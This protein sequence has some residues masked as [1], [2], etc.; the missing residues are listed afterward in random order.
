VLGLVMNII[1]ALVMV[2]VMI[3]MFNLLGMR[4]SAVRGDF[5]LYIMS[6]V[7]NYATHSKAIS[8]VARS[9][10]PTST[11]MQHAPMNT[12]V[13]ICSSALSALY[14]QTLSAFCILFFY[15]T[16]W[17]RITIYDPVGVFGMYLL[18]WASGIGVGMILKAATPWQPEFF[19]IITMLYTRAN[20][21]FSGKMFLANTLSER[22]LYLYSWNPLFHCIDQTRG[23][24][25]ENYHPRNSS[26]EYPIV[27]TFVLIVI[28]LMAEN[29]AKKHA[30]ASWGARR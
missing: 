29:F 3:A 14:L 8:A 13:A 26:L 10:G 18:S 2:G 25:F 15:H 4:G 17:T 24:M 6:G 23:Y 28:G 16:L 19:S 21:I 5:T 22:L 30:S 7:F 27:V 9:E 1:Q 20:M 11:M 12:I